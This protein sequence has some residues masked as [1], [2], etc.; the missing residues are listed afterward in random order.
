MNQSTK[1]QFY[2]ASQTLLN[3]IPAPAPGSKRSKVLGFLKAKHAEYLGGSAEEEDFE[4]GI[5]REGT[6]MLNDPF[7]D[8][9]LMLYPSYCRELPNGQYEVEVRGW[10]YM[11]GVV[12]RK[13]KII[14]GLARQIT[15][16]NNSGPTVSWQS[17]VGMAT[18]NLGTTIQTSTEKQSL[19]ELADE[20]EKDP[21]V[22]RLE[23][24]AAEESV[25]RR[26]NR[27]STSSSTTS[28]SSMR[29]P[30]RD[31]KTLR[32]RLAP[33]LARSA[34]NRKLFVQIGRRR[35]NDEEGQGTYEG[36]NTFEAITTSSGRFATRCKVPYEPNGVRV[37]ASSDVSAVGDVIGISNYGLSVITDIDDTIKHTGVRG[38]KREILRNVLIKEHTLIGIEGVAEWYNRLKE[39]GCSFHYVS[40]SPWQLYSTISEY[41]AA[42]NFP[43]GSIHLKQY[44]GIMDGLFEPASERKRTTLEA[45]VKDFPERKFILIGDSGEGDLEAYVDLAIAYP[46]QISAIYI[47]DITLPVEET[48]NGSENPSVEQQAAE[49]LMT[50]GYI[51]TPD[52][53]DAFEKRQ[54]QR[55][56]FRSTQ[57]KSSVTLPIRTPE[58][59][60]TTVEEDIPDLI[61]LAPPLP[62]RPAPKPKP[63]PVPRKPVGLQGNKIEHK[64][65][66]PP[67][68]PPRSQRRSPYVNGSQPIE[69]QS[70]PPPSPAPS[71][72]PPPPPRRPVNTTPAKPVSAGSSPVK[73]LSR[74]STASLEPP[75]PHHINRPATMPDMHSEPY[76]MPST[77]NEYG[78]VYELDKKVENWKMRVTQAR[79]H[80]PTST[81]LRMWRRSTDVEQ[82][83]LLIV[84]SYK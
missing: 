32:Q 60:R 74:S 31:D 13:G 40:N 37:E 26:I 81:R 54:Q 39:K 50:T 24:V 61:E 70:K 59:A 49:M 3:R 83:T 65:T 14:H 33:F 19:I 10:L 23:S 36:T 56:L 8:E 71:P 53:I 5:N 57:T 43:P 2:E 64:P 17:S 73:P 7:E 80:L 22:K 12:N 45:I 35:Q 25:N 78:M 79:Y 4:R 48:A 51:P 41:L 52:E 1:N 42:W 16:L 30:V 58:E 44:S 63:P 75:I 28:T 9:Q 27:S 72:P 46:K 38:D 55:S 77:Q 69:V 76:I 82:E 68:P 11:N 62:A 34:P 6:V 47:R 15:G 84:E 20:D 66:P 29:D 18:S 21:D 67:P